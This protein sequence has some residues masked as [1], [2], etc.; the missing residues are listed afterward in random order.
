MKYNL[1]VYKK[2]F[3]LQ[4]LFFVSCLFYAFCM[5]LAHKK[6]LLETQEFWG[7]TYYGLNNL[8]IFFLI[9]VIFLTSIFTS[10][11]IDTPSK[12]IIYMLYIIVFI[13]TLT[14]T[15]A[16]REDSLQVYGITL[17][18]LIIGY[19][20]LTIKK[21]IPKSDSNYLPS[22]K[23][24]YFFVSLF[25]FCFFSLFIIFRDII[26]FVGLDNIYSQRALGKSSN[27]FQG[28]MLTYLP[29]VICAALMAFG[30]I[31]KKILYV[32]MAFCG[33]FLI[34]GIAAQRAVFL[35]P[36]IIYLLYLYMRNN[37]FE[38]KYLI[39]FNL[40]IS[41][42][43]AFISYLPSGF[44]RDFLGFYI[45]T[46]IFAT[47]GIM[48]SHYHDVFYPDN[49]TYWS[50]I[51]G[52]SL[53][54]QRPPAY[55]YDN[56]W[57]QLGWIVAKYK[58]GIISNSNANLFA[59]DGVAAA[60]G[61]GIVV[62]CIIFYFYLFVFDYLSKSI[63]VKFKVIVAFPIGLALTNGSLATILLSFGGFFWLLILAY[64]MSNKSYQ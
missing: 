44:L 33:Y 51:K 48:F 23:I 49:L 37:K 27:L 21:P 56:D 62:L 14:L 52:F 6:Y 24:E 34:F 31:K 22:K 9:V 2:D 19:L 26:N 57:P 64:I 3:Y 13:P 39:Y 55:M 59:A 12:I 40:F 10:L 63:D 47:P 35:M 18:F 28:Y 53:I 36:F 61:I 4:F 54:I 15:L 29:N 45:L 20:I 11:R 16:L 58:L 30:L 43:F 17:I 7:Y 46:R 32:F 50:H 41:F 60:G 5:N 25:L 38:K 1:I 8:E 42:I